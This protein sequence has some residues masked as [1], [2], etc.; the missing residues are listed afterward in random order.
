MLAPTRTALVC[1]LAGYYACLN[2][3]A[4]VRADPAAHFELRLAVTEQDAVMELGNPADE[5][6]QLELWVEITGVAPEA[7]VQAFSVYL[8]AS[9]NGVVSFDGTFDDSPFPFVLPQGTDNVP[10]TGDFSRAGLTT[11][12]G[13]SAGIGAPALYGRFTI[14]AIGAGSVA[15]SF[16]DA[17]GAVRPWQVKIVN[18]PDLVGDDLTYSISPL[19]ASIHVIPPVVTPDADHDGDVDLADYSAMI[20]CV[21]EGGALPSPACASRD[22]NGDTHV[23][24]NDLQMFVAA[25]TGPLPEQ[26]DLD[27]DGDV[28]LRDFSR[29]QTCFFVEGLKAENEACQFADIDRDE[30]TGM[31]DFHLLFDHL[32]GPGAE[33]ELRSSASH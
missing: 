31:A 2:V 21:D 11:M 9:A 33:G 5:T 10:F 17:G 25:L 22:L 30:E 29:M 1:A 26:G 14:S 20:L 27:A 23:D 24:R 28:D 15:Y 16:S 7:L 6:L 3:P 18:L 8:K 4:D 32:S 13:V 19:V 12:T